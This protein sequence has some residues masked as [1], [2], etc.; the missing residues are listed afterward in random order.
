MLMFK[1]LFAKAELSGIKS[2]TSTLIPLAVAMRLDIKILGKT[3]V[4]GTHR[5]PR[6][7]QLRTLEGPRSGALAL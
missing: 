7:H 4:L 2:D 6:R 1:H 3:S 5:E